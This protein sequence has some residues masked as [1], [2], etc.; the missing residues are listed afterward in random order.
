MY[1]FIYLFFLLVV[2]N[3]M[4][5]IAKPRNHRNNYFQDTLCFLFCFVFVFVFYCARS[6]VKNLIDLSTYC[7]GCTS[8]G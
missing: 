6:D 1:Y 5:V 8:I 3:T 4:F 7:I 2:I